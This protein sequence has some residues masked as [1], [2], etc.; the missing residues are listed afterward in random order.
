MSK[1]VTIIQNEKGLQLRKTF[2]ELYEY[3]E[4]LWMLAWRDFRVRYAQTF[5]GFVWAILEP[6]ATAVLLSLVFNKVA[7]ASTLGIEPILFGMTGM[8]CWNYFSNVVSQGNTSLILAQ[9]M[10]KKIYFPRMIIPLS[11]AIAALPDLL[12]TIIFTTIL[13]IFSESRILV[14]SW[15]FPLHIILTI[16]TAA[17]L[18][19]CFSALNIRFRDFKHVV[20]FLIRMGMFI[21]PIAYSTTEINPTYKALFFLNPMS[22]IIESL[23]WAV[24]GIPVEKVYLWISAASLLLFFVGGILL[25][26][27]LQKNI[28]DII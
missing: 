19:I 27:T 12:I 10:I 13:L 26:N 21:T 25:F 1:K 9:N 2:R 16:L 15:I 8:I 22:G 6:L 28:A 24:F 5:L 11:K 20:P 18:G 7:N 23:R 14:T 4:L 3:R 17:S